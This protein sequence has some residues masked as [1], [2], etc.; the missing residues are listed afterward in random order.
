[1]RQLVP[2]ISASLHMAS[3]RAET[4]AELNQ[5]WLVGSSSQQVVAFTYLLLRPYYHISRMRSDESRDAHSIVTAARVACDTAESPM[6]SFRSAH[7]ALNTLGAATTQKDL[8]MIEHAALRQVILHQCVKK[9]ARLQK[10]S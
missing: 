9:I 1:M 6:A 10:L 2:E 7:M 3:A 8:P 4:S 5:G